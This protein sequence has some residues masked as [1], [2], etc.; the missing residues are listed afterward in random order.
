MA[1]HSSA[2]IDFELVLYSSLSGVLSWAGTPQRDNRLDHNIV[3][4]ILG[5][6]LLASAFRFATKFSLGSKAEFLQN[7]VK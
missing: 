6:I 2:M 5:L 4:D 3:R 1:E 7:T